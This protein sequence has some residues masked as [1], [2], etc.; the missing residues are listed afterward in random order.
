MYEKLHGSTKSTCPK[1]SDT[2]AQDVKIW[3]QNET[4]ATS[5]FFKKRAKIKEL[6]CSTN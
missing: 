6:R 3:K 2:V 4:R 1:S 5:Y